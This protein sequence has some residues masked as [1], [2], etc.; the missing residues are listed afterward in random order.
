MSPNY[1]GNPPSAADELCVFISYPRSCCWFLN[2]F[3][4]P[5]LGRC[6]TIVLETIVLGHVKCTKFCLNTR[7]SLNFNLLRLLY[8]Y[9]S[10]SKLLMEFVYCRIFQRSPERIFQP[11]PSSKCSPPKKNIPCCERDRKAIISWWLRCAICKGLP[12]VRPSFVARC[13]QLGFVP[14]VDPKD[15]LRDRVGEKIWASRFSYWV[16]LCWGCC[17]PVFQQNFL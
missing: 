13:A 9:I 10:K 11:L 5:T 17:I 2:I 4:S 7:I 8:L 12:I 6:Q 3:L 15:L 16:C 14:E 1:S